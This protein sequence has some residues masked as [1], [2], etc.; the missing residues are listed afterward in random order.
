[1]SRINIFTDGCAE[2][3]KSRRNA[4]FVAALAEDFNVVVT[5][6]YAPTASF[7]TMVDGQGNVRKA[8][9]RKLERDEVEGT[10]CPTSYD[11]FKLFTSKYPMAP[12]VVEDSQRNPMTIA[13]RFHRFLVDKVDA[14]PDMIER[15][16]KEKDVIITDY[17]EERW[18]APPVKGIKGIFNLIAYK[19]QGQI[20]L[21]SR[22]HSCFCSSC[23]K[24]DFHRCGYIPT[25]G[26]LREEQVKKLPFKEPA[27]LKNT[28]CDETKRINFFKVPLPL[29]SETNIFMLLLA[30]KKTLTMSRFSWAS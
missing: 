6:N 9:Y 30:R 13:R 4:Y 12:D 23:I 21:F 25:S 2:Q 27:F 28:S 20:K 8:F 26:P 10:R 29:S 7:K 24:N 17:I 16:T 18:D 19:E 22:Q 3:Y 15:A 1:M 14:T 11:L 5:H